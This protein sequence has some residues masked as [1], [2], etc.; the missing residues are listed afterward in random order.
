MAFATRITGK[1]SARLAEIDPGDSG[2][3]TEEEGE[4]QLAPLREELRE[5]QELVFAASSNGILVILQGMDAAGKDVTIGD[6]FALADPASCRV[7]AFKEPTPEEGAHHFLWRADRVTPALGEL[8][9]FDRS[10]YEQ[11]ILPQVY[12]DEPEEEIERKHEHIV[13]YER[14]LRDAG[15]IVMKFFLHV[16]NAEQRHRLE[17]RQENLETA[18]KISARDWE[19]R[20][21]WDAY[22]AAYDVTMHATATRD[23]AWHV[24][25]AD[26][27]WFHNLA[28]AEALAE[29][30]RPE[31]ERWVRE[32]NRRGRE[33][34]QE[35]EQARG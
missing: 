16:G 30:L 35:A 5:L 33:K 11:A 10:Y 31:R 14:L 3:L 26:A 20:E 17:E 28:V 27:Q 21:Q 13:A 23:A 15:T 6:V 4:Q 34:R 12:G 1:R 8:V 2:G 9:I 32:R 24:V 7:A 25:P 19:A 29:R 22:M 18:W